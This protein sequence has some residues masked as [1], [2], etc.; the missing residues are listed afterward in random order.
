MPGAQPAAAASAPSNSHND[1]GAQLAAAALAQSLFA[2]AFVPAATFTGPRPG[3]FYQ[4]GPCGMGYY[5][6]PAAPAQPASAA[7]TAVATTPT[8]AATAPTAPQAAQPV[9]P[10]ASTPPAQPASAEVAGLSDGAAAENAVPPSVP[11]PQSAAISDPVK[12]GAAAPSSAAVE[13]ATQPNAA[14]AP[15]AEAANIAVVADA[16]PTTNEEMR[17]KSAKLCASHARAEYN[18]ERFRFMTTPRPSSNHP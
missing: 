14:A 15:I 2:S 17:D 16:E 13:A 4:N 12:P 18:C 3:F 9:A 5:K 8:A 11:P 6:E 7:P 10:A 1:P